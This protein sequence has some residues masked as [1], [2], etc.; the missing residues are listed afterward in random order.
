[1]IVVV[2]VV[3]LSLLVVLPAFAASGGRPG[4][5]VV[6]FVTSQDLLYDSIVGPELPAKGPFQKLEVVNNQLTT[7]FG[8]RD[9]GYVGDRWWLDVNDNNQMDATDLYFSCPLLGP[10]RESP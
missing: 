7:E 9:R 10:G 5:E 1:M 2:F 8:P 4:S 3:A 6:I